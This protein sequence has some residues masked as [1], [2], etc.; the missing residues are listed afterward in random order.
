[1]CTR[2]LA[3]VAKVHGYNYLR[4]ILAPL[5]DEMTRHPQPIDRTF[6]L[7]SGKLSTAEI[8]ANVESIKFIA[9]GFLNVVTNSAQIL[10]P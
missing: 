6:N 8:E 5:L 3:G 1:M 10:P 2:L 4:A 7:D 9:H